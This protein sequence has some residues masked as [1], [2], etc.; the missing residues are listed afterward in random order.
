MN[1]KSFQNNHFHVLCIWC[2]VEIRSDRDEDS[3]GICLQ[4]FYRILSEQ[5][6]SHV[7][8]GAGQFASER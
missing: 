7:R 4:C 3:F 6:R 5:L 1:N 2:G 8:S